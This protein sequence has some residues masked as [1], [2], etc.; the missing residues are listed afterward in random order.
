MKVDQL[1]LKWVDLS[2]DLWGELGAGEWVWCWV[3]ERADPMAVMSAELR[4]VAWVVRL[5]AV[6]AGCWVCQ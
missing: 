6:K 1:D 4:A 5:A 2:V 3:G